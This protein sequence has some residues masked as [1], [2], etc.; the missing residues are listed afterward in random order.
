MQSQKIQCQIWYDATPRHV[1]RKE[2]YRVKTH[3]ETVVYS[4]IFN[5]HHSKN[6]RDMEA[7]WTHFKRKQMLL[8]L[9]T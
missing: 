5:D 2:K 3:P 6:E 9:M 4:Q 8:Q 7:G 1:R